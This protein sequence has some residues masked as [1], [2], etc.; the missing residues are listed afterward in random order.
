MKMCFLVYLVK[1]CKSSFLVEKQISNYSNI[2]EKILLDEFC[3]AF[4]LRFLLI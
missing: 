4:L 1:K 3:F 2:S